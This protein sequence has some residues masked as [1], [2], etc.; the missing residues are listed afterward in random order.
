[1]TR[2]RFAV[3]DT[4]VLLAVYNRKDDDH[5]RAVQTLSL[6]DRLVVSPLVLA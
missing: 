6:V 1:V 3:A 2:H 4:S 5:E